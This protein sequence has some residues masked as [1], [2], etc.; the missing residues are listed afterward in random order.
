M[1]E[2]LVPYFTRH[3]GGFRFQIRVPTA[4]RPR[5]G[6][7]IRVDLQT[8]DVRTAKLLSLRLA[9]EWLTRFSALPANDDP[10][11]PALPPSGAPAAAPQI[12]EERPGLTGAFEYWRDLTPD[13]PVRTV[14]EFERTAEA[15]DEIVRKPLSQLTRRDIANFRDTLLTDGLSAATVKKNLGFVSTLIQTQFDAGILSTNIAQG[16]RV[17]RRKVPKLGRTGFT[18]EQLEAVFSSPVFSRGLR[19]RG[20]GGEAAAWL[21]ILAYATGARVAEL[22][23]LRTEDLR[24]HPICGLV[25][26]IHDDGAAAAVKT[27]SSRRLVPIH[28][29]VIAA[30]FLQYV[31]L[32]RKHRDEW[33]FPALRPDVFKNRSGT[34]LKWWG[35]Y[36][37]NPNGCNI[38]DSRVVFHSFRHS[39]KT[40]CRAPAPGGALGATIISEEVHDALT[41]HTG[42]S[43]S[44]RYG[45]VPLDTLVA[46]IGR[47]KLPVP[48]PKIPAR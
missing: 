38:S 21:P 28:A 15:F 44:R 22:C 10:D 47:L 34:W 40:F 33:L 8:Q 18:P 6:T 35:R 5:Y 48:I 41:G 42:A 1:P 4:A 24:D 29:D 31:E 32:R 14:I 19:P 25:I 7:I 3:G 26:R 45:T 11:E 23:Q 9:A 30:G 12:V 20:G 27:E 17:P 13:R 46:A 2:A 43:V 37:R 39:F 36:L 16:L